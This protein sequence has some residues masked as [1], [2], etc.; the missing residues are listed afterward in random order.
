MAPP[1]PP[2]N[3]SF[4][5]DGVNDDL[6]ASGVLGNMRGDF[7]LG[8]G[9]GPFPAWALQPKRETGVRKFLA[10]NPEFDGRNTVIA[11]FDSGWLRL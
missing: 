10:Q 8:S 4:P 1:G 3:E 9:P 5:D 2:S 11:I 6:V 7:V